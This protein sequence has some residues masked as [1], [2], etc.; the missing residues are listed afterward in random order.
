MIPEGRR[1]QSFRPWLIQAILR[2]GI[3]QGGPFQGI[4]FFTSSPWSGLLAKLLGVYEAELTPT[5]VDWKGKQFSHVINIGSADGYH[6]LG[7]AKLWPSAMIIAYE[8]EQSGREILQES[9]MHNGFD[10]RIQCRSTCTPE[11]FQNVLKEAS[12]GLVIMDV[13]G[14]EDELLADKSRDLLRSFHLIVELHDLRIDHL[15]DRLMERFSETHTISEVW[16][17]KRRWRDFS[18]PKNPLLRSYLLEQLRDLADEE[19][20]APMRWFIFEPIPC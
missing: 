14:G 18:F 1:P 8:T 6:A 10:G 19:R 9:V 12:S 17:Q 7:S 5:L 2:K 15:G 11:E 4:Y 3:I 20:G 13:E 16:T